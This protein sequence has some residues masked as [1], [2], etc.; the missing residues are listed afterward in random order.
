MSYPF[1]YSD[2]GWTDLG[3][4]AVPQVADPTG[5]LR[6]WAL[7]FVRSN[8]TDTLS[9]PKQPGDL[10]QEDQV[11]LEQYFNGGPLYCDPCWEKAPP[12][13]DCGMHVAQ[14]QAHAHAKQAHSHADGS[15]SH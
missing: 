5:Y 7:Q 4:P 13:D 12:C 8:P 14:E 1:R 10:S 11:R 6:T 15:A 2:D 9:L 3:A